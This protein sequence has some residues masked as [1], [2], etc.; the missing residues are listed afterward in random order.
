M[1]SSSRSDQIVEVDEGNFWLNHPKL[2]QVAWSIGAF[3]A[4]EG[5]TESIDGTQCGGTELTLQL[6]ADGQ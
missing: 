5:R 2:S 6:S 3:S 1:K 4:R